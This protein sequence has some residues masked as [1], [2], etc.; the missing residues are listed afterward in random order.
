[1]G[2][3]YVHNKK[4]QPPPPLLRKKNSTKQNLKKSSL[5]VHRIKMYYYFIITLSLREASNAILKYT[6]S[7][8][9]KL[10]LMHDFTK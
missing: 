10:V 9:I 3:K 4:N 5:S 7:N 1:M 6:L 8:V 2:K